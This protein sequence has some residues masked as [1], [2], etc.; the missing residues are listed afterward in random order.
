M[1]KIYL[2]L[3]SAIF[4]TPFSQNAQQQVDPYRAIHDILM[5]QKKTRYSSNNPNVISGVISPASHFTKPAGV[6]VSN[7]SEEELRKKCAFFGGD[8]L[9]GFNFNLAHQEALADGCKML[10][11]YYSAIIKREVSFV[12]K[13][14]NISEPV[15]NAGNSPAFKSSSSVASLPSACSNVDFE[16][17]NF[18]GWTAVSGYNSNSNNPLTIPASALTVAVT[19]TNQNIYGCADVNMITS[20]YGTDPIG[21]FPGVDPSGGSYSVRL[22][23]FNINTDDGDGYACASQKWNYWGPANGE[24]I[25][26]TIAVTAANSLLSFDYAVVLN[27]GGHPNGQQPYFHVYV[28]NTAGTVLS[29]CTQYYV[30]A[31]A[32][33]PPA[34]FTNSGFVNTYD[35]SLLYYKGWTSNSIN[36]TPYIG[37]NVKIRF[38]AAG[39][40]NGGHMGWAY[41][42]AICGSAIVNSSNVSPCAGTNVLLTAPPVAGGSY[43]WTGPGVTGLTTQ[44]VN[45]NTS[46]TY[47]VV[48]T[49]SQGATCTYTLTRVVTYNPLPSVSA[50]ATSSINCT[51]LSTQIGLS[52]TM[53]PVTF[54]TTGPGVTGGGSTSSV[55]VNQGGTYNYT[56]TNSSTGCL[57]TGSVSVVKDISTVTVNSSST[58]SL[59]CSVSSATISLTSSSASV[60]YNTSGPGIV[61][62]N[63][64]SAV[65]VNA[66]GTYNYSV[67]NN[68]N[69]CVTTGAIS[70]NQNTVP[71]TVSASPTSSL[72]CT[73]LSTQ[74]AL[75]TTSSPVSFNTTGPGV[76]GGATSSSVTVNQPGTYNYTVTNTFNNCFT[77]GSVS[78][79]QNTTAPTA[80]ITVPSVLN[81]T[82][83]SMVLNGN[84]TSGVTYS[85]SGPSG[86]TSTNQNPSVSLPG[87]YNLTVTSTFNNCKTVT[88]TAVTQNTAVS[89][90]ASTSGSVTCINSVVSLSASPASMNYTWTAPGGSSVGSANTQTTSA[91]GAGTYSLLLMNP[92]NGCTAVAIVAAN[93]NTVQGVPNAS[94]TGTVNCN[95]S[96]VNLN[97]TT[98]GV[99]YTWSAPAGSSLSNANLQSPVGTGGGT[100]TLT[101]TNSVNGC[102]NFNTVAVTTQT[103]KPTPSISNN[104][105]LTCSNSTVVVN[106]GPASGV[107]YAWSG[108]G[109]V[110][111]GSSANVSVNAPGVYSLAVTSA[112]NGCSSVSPATVNVTQNVVTPTLSAVSSQTA[113][114]G[115]GS[116]SVVVLSGTATPA[117]SSYTWTSSGGFVSGVNNG[118][119]SVNSATTYTLS[120]THPVTGCISSMVFTVVPSANQ[121]TLTGSASTGTLTC[122][123][124][125][126]SA[127]VSSNPASGVSYAWSGPG[128]V[129]ASNTSAITGSVAGTY[130]VVVTNTAN[131]CSNVFSYIVSAD[132]SPVSPN[133][134]VSNS[135]NCV[136]SSA[137]LAAAPSPGSGPFTYSWSTSASSASVVVS[138]LVTTNYVVTVT[139][140]AN[141]CT[142]SQTITATANT[143]PPTAVGVS[144]AN[145]TLSCATPTTVLSASATGAVSY[146]WVNSGGSIITPANQSTVGIQGGGSYS[147]IATAAN[148]CSAAAAVATITPDNNAPVFTVSNSSPSITCLTASPSVS[149]SVTSTVPVS[150]SWSPASGI[151]GSASLSTV[152]FTAQ[153]VYTVVVTATNGCVSSS[154]VAVTNATTAPSLVA[155][156][157]T[158]QA[159]SCTNS[160]VTVAP[161]FT[162]SANLT[163]SWAGPG[164][165]GAAN[166][167]SVMVNAPGAYSLVLTNSVTG[168]ST[169]SVVV[170]VSG[171]NV[172]PSVSVAS[173]SSIGITCLP[174]SSSVTLTASSSATNVS[175]A[176]SGGATS[177]AISTS[178]AGVYTVTVTDNVSN[179]SSTATVNVLNNSSA[180]SFSAASAGNLPCG[181]SGTTALV[182]N[183]SNTNVSYAWS[184]PGVVSGANAA[185]AVVNAAGVYSLTVTDIVT[186]CSASS[187]LA[188]TQASVSALAAADFTS[189][190]APLNVNFSDLGSGASTY[191][192]S[193]GNGASASSNAASTSYTAGGT[194]TAVLIASNGSCLA[195]D[196]VVII[197][198]AGLGEIPE[199]FTPNGDPYNPTFS[200]P[201]LESYPNASLQ[202]FNRWGNPVYSANP[203]KNDWDGS[204]NAAGKTGSGKLP[205]GTYFF[206][207]ELN[208]NAK[209]I[210]KGF[211]QLQY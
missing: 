165:V 179:C 101:V 151:A 17:G 79:V 141:G 58:A 177:A 160:V 130:S 153:G 155:G 76:T 142:G 1:K 124:T 88:N 114:S 9:N 93:V 206:I 31:S 23:G 62:G 175:Y 129:G 66:G 157:G 109:V 154:T 18:G 30:Q 161:S 118:S 83:T 71:V 119:V 43:N 191:S 59:N 181:G 103:A 116:S 100:Y 185:S 73:T 148:G 39:C 189:G 182:A 110:S 36:L 74:I 183:A 48:V 138:P 2:A 128:I 169:S 108:P 133:A 168:C 69:N 19:A 115:C 65:V 111:G 166:N 26:K 210:F 38:V 54:N 81:C 208:D 34:G 121:P 211:I 180:P 199:V 135:V 75:S 136:S 193:F 187:T 149:V 204:A 132:N 190:T 98:T 77:S 22:G 139:N 202:V 78:V 201:G 205:T 156:T 35:G 85:W 5:A 12:R 72:N 92:A 47:S 10:S 27:D 94:S 140:T 194:Y 68:F 11:E 56:V 145:F 55:T 64:S 44:T 125:T 80:S 63:T 90:S 104:P 91:T 4:F 40:S 203:Y 146:T 53:T 105:T 16:D 96:T 15:N 170:P 67:T 50:A 152:N 107:S 49:P 144:P 25:E 13:K 162:P 150:Y 28:T 131:N 82:N 167:A 197:V 8:T 52:T 7:F 37:S 198:K 84:P 45:V 60:T 41:V 188:I 32:G 95:T 61:S 112:S 87:T 46:G 174:S 192:W 70:V 195:S 21:L 6:P 172:V 99:T 120:S 207:L 209:S 143:N 159:L 14:Y 134:T 123:N 122:L 3:I 106:G 200:I 171:S 184:G 33:T 57:T 186:G 164:I 176:W 20:A 24:Y 86:F 196:T 147:V 89:A 42:D 163:Y 117:G 29:T 158:A 51:N 178:A 127:T 137:T 97:S 102:T 126:Q 113:A 173:S